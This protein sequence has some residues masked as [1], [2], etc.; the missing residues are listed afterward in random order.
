MRHIGNLLMRL[1]ATVGFVFTI[2]AFA[3]INGSV[4]RWLVVGVLI[5]LGLVASLGLMASGA[6]LVRIV[7]RR[8]QRLASPK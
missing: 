8:A 1:G 4:V 6:A 5:K 2:L 7:N 3:S